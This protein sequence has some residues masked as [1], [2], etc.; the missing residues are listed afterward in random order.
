MIKFR[1][2]QIGEVIEHL[3]D[4]EINAEIN[5][6]WDAGFSFGVGDSING[7]C[8]GCIAPK[9]VEIDTYN[10]SHIISALAWMAFKRYPES[11]FAKWYY[12][13]YAMQCFVDAVEDGR[14]TLVSK[15]KSKGVLEFK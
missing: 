7:W 1:K 8:N 6:F 4:S 2:D 12:N 15:T 9:N 10:I 3:Y 11:D 5:W 14:L 13:E